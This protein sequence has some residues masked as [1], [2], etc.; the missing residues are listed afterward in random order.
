MAMNDSSLIYEGK[1]GLFSGKTIR[2][3][4]SSVEYG[5]SIIPLKDIT[6]LKWGVAKSLLKSSY[7]I[8][9]KTDEKIVEIK[10]N[11]TVFEDSLKV[12]WDTVGRR[13]IKEILIAFRDGK[14][15]GFD[16]NIKDEGVRFVQRTYTSFSAR[17]KVEDDTGEHFETKNFT[18]KHEEPFDY[19]WSQISIGDEDN[20]FCIYAPDGNCILSFSSISFYNAQMLEY[21]IRV[22]HEKRLIKLSDL[23]YQ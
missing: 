19:D 3:S 23:L 14:D 22:A 9:I 6:G 20:E 21:I 12:L 1:W 18:T 10:T 11:K 8:N 16:S 17:V 2:I 15:T 5:S 13:I 4:K 7:F